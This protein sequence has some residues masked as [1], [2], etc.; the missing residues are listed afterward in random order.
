MKCIE[1][2]EMSSEQHYL[3]ADM[4]LA[5]LYLHKEIN[6]P[7][8]DPDADYLYVHSL[9]QRNEMLAFKHLHRAAVMGPNKMNINLS[10]AV[11]LLLELY[12][13]RLDTQR[14]LYW[15]H[16]YKKT[17]IDDNYHDDDAPNW[18]RNYLRCNECICTSPRL[19]PSWPLPVIGT[20]PCSSG[21]DHSDNT[22]PWITLSVTRDIFESFE[23]QHIHDHVGAASSTATG[24]QPTTVLPSIVVFHKEV[25]TKLGSKFLVINRFN[26]PLSLSSSLSLPIMV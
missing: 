16:F 12:A 7:S 5:R 23:W 6:D 26:D 14:Y 17:I 20:S 8:S 24:M 9:I 4:E 21:I 25:G 15:A 11:T 13:K 18:K 3:A 22:P 10:N 2:W 19:T 1:L